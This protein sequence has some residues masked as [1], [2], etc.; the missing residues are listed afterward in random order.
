MLLKRLGWSSMTIKFIEELIFFLLSV[1]ENLKIFFGKY[2]KYFIKRRRSLKNF[3]NL[4]N[5]E[6]LSYCF[7]KLGTQFKF[8]VV[9]WKS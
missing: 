3:E 6:N 5:K 8:S 4:V 9:A 7:G 2:R 1:N